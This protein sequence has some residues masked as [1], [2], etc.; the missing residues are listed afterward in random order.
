M[1]A[2]PDTPEV[3]WVQETGGRTCARWSRSAPLAC[4]RWSDPGPTTRWS[5]GYGLNGELRDAG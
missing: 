1:L 4:A 5:A 2:A 3:S